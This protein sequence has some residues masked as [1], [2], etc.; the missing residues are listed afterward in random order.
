MPYAQSIT[1][2]LSAHLGWHRVR[3]KFMARFT[4][5][6]LKMTTTNL[7][8]SAIA[9]KAEVKEVSNCRCIRRFL[10]SYEMD[11]AVLGRFLTR[12]LPKS[13]PYKV[14]NDR[15]EWHFGTQPVNVLMAG[16]AHRGVAFPISWT[17]L[18]DG[19]SSSASEH[20]RALRCFSQVVEPSEIEA[21]I[22]GREFI[23]AKWLGWLQA[24]E[25]PF[26][27]RLRSDRHL[28][29]PEGTS[30]PAKVLA[31]PLALRQVKVLDREYSLRG[32]D[33]KSADV[34]VVLKRV[35]DRSAED[36]F[37]ILATSGIDP[38]E[39]TGLYREH[40]QVE[41]LFAALKSR[42]C[43]LERT[44]LTEP[45]RVQRLIGLLVLA[46]GWTWLVGERRVNRE[47]LPRKKP[48]DR[49]ERSLFRY[50]LVRL[51]SILAAPAPQP[52][53]FFECIRG[54]RSPT[55]FLSCI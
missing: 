24:R 38:A 45:D 5:A 10:S 47:G 17:V 33:G 35:A 1:D 34:R 21:V 32:T 36:Q 49:Q 15:T 41:T 53:A 27:V 31:R 4:A 18:P 29:S 39:A 50:G 13:A 54:V 46:F 3:L 26:L 22:A 43:D 40:W 51:R 37:L 12:L 55:A 23:S 9:L 6:L 19:G 8:E 30:L 11:F 2:V 44:H 20:C 52:A 25:I 28:V 16:I 42:G 7:R 48:H 14:V